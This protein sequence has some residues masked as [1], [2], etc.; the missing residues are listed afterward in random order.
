MRSLLTGGVL[1]C[2]AAAGTAV[3][4]PAMTRSD[5]KRIAQAVQL[6]TSDL[7]GYD[8]APADSSGNSLGDKR[9]SRCAG[10]VP[11]SKALADVESNQFSRT[12]AGRFEQL[13]SEA[14]V[15]PTAALVTKDMKAARSKR[16]R[17]CLAKQLRRESTGDP[18]MKLVSLAVSAL[19][20]AVKNGVGMRVKAVYQTPNGKVTVFTDALV[21]GIKQVEAGVVVSGGPKAP[22]R[23]EE[24]D[25]LKIVTSRVKDELASSAVY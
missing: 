12:V 4:M 20:P 19:R 7:P 9:F 13:N 11:D 22:P 5:A 17:T 6:T 15:Y 1:A 2:L 16:A 14:L 8:E 24:N 21:V 25:L 10:T 23:S 3:A 18:N